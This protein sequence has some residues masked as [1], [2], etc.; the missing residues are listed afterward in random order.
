MN[1]LGDNVDT[2]I[3]ASKEDSLEIDV[4]KTT[5]RLNALAQNKDTYRLLSRH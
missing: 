3:D 2:L 1:L 4:E 5:Y